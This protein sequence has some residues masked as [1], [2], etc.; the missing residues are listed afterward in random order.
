MLA[1]G[2]GIE[3]SYQDSKSC[4]LPLDDPSIKNTYIK[5]TKKDKK[6]TIFI[7]FLKLKIMWYYE[8]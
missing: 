4:V 7:F 5:Y 6:T 1:E 3:P 2:E 8:D